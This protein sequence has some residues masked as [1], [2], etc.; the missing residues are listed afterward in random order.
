M[1][2][3]AA[4]SRKLDRFIAGAA[5][6]ARRGAH[7]ETTA[8]QRED[9]A[10]DLVGEMVLKRFIALNPSSD[11]AATRI[12]RVLGYE[13]PAARLARA[14]DDFCASYNGDLGD[15][16]HLN[17]YETIRALLALDPE[18]QSL[19]PMPVDSIT[20]VPGTELWKRCSP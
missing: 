1:T 19:M 15:D 11:S 4:R 20:S 6:N 2:H 5:D 12:S 14:W 16:D 13:A 9:L 17:Q 3:V 18:L 7:V 10:C 8:D